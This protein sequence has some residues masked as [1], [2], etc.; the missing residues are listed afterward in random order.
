M[1]VFSAHLATPVLGTPIPR[2]TRVNGPPALVRVTV[3]VPVV[4][5]AN[6]RDTAPF[7]VSR[8]ANVD[9]V[10]EV[11]VGV[12]VGVVVVSLPHAEVRTASARAAT[13]PMCARDLMVRY[14]CTM[15]IV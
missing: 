1:A 7:G 15:R 6:D 8:L 3:T 2:P 12:G 9:V 4:V 13:E 11:V 14:G 5:A 10:G